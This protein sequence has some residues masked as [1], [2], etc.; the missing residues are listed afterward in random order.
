MWY[1]IIYIIIIDKQM[2]IF[3]IPSSAIVLISLLLNKDVCYCVIVPHLFVIT[4]SNV[5]D[6]VLRDPG[7][8]SLPVR[9]IVFKDSI[10]MK[11]IS[12]IKWNRTG[13]STF[14]TRGQPHFSIY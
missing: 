6:S 11:T 10:V 4:S 1:Y 13:A 12:V 7:E 14:G 2:E 8:V 3:H 5:R 9:G